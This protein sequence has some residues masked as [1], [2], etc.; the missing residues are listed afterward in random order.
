MK[1]FLI[2]PD[3]AADEPSPEIDGKTPLE[4]ARTPNLDKM[5]E[6]ALVGAVQVTPVEM[7]PGSDVA[8]MSL[9]GYDP[10]RY[11]TGR[12][13]IE[14]AAMDIPLDA[15]DVAFRCSLISTDGQT[16]LD[17]SAG[18]ITTEE[19]R[20][21]IE[22][23]NQKLCAR[24]QR[25]FTGVSY[26]HIMRWTDGPTEL[27]THPPHESI[28]K[29][30]AEIYP[31][32]DMDS[33]I[34]A[35]S[36]DSL[37]LLNDLP[38][39]KQRREEG[40]SPANMLW[41]WSPGRTPELPAFDKK[42]GMTGAVISAVDVVRGLGKLTGL[43]IVSVPGAT[44]YFDTNYAGKAH[45]AVAAT[46]RHDFVWIHIESPDEAGH[47]GNI[48]EK[49]RAVENIDKLVIGTLLEQMRKRDDFRILI[50]P[51]HKTPVALRR[52]SVGPV[53]FML[54]DSR[55]ALRSGGALPYDERAVAE[56]RTNL[57]EG[58]RLIEELFAE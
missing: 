29:K 52:H 9:L 14:A 53:P 15:K 32:G 11:Y 4:V 2:V 24:Y 48:D 41:P 7:Y 18:H 47:E 36:E 30:L 56:A 31:Q 25:L 20:P 50:S 6:Q 1:Y 33:K 38:F 44:G 46:E 26:R 12:G 49:I 54:Y 42:R 35:F 10:T 55:K 5:A 34:R 57:P 21:I 27:L 51:D 37:N 17:Y 3:G 13:P 19:A 16:M 45:A 40:K 39:N 58:Y 22:L 28:N 23:A 43:E 8:N